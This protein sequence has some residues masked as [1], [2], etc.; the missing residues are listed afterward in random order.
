DADKVV[1]RGEWQWPL[2]I[3]VATAPDEGIRETCAGSEHLDAG[4]ARAGVGHCRLFRQFEDIGAAE[5]SDTNVLPRHAGNIEMGSPLVA[6]K[7]SLWVTSGYAAASTL[8][9][10]CADSGRRHLRKREPLGR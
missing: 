2:E 7:C 1:T 6:R 8:S 3:W 5:M 10:L 9:L 4:L